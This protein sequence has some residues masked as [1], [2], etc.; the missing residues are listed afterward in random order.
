M[1]KMSARYLLLI[2]V[3][4]VFITMTGGCDLLPWGKKDLNFTPAAQE[5]PG[6]REVS[7]FIRSLKRGKTNKAADLL[8]EEARVRWNIRLALMPDN[9]RKELLR[10]IRADTFL[11]DEDVNRFIIRGKTTAPTRAKVVRERGKRRLEF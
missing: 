7:D 3:F 11:I 5:T 4:A 1:R 10:D 2:S 9:E 6:F 8:S